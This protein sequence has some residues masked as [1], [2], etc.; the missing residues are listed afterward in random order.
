MTSG[1]KNE[2]V[3]ESYTVVS[4][5]ISS[6]SL[7]L[8]VNDSVCSPADNFVQK[9]LELPITNASTD[10]PSSSHEAPYDWQFLWS[11]GGP[12][13][14]LKNAYGH[15]GTGTIGSMTDMLAT[16]S[17][18]VR[19]AYALSFGFCDGQRLPCTV[20]GNDAFFQNQSYIY[21]TPSSADWMADLMN[22][23]AS[24]KRK[25]FCAFA[26]PGAHDAGMWDATALGILAKESK[27]QQYMIDFAGE[28][29]TVAKAWLIAMAISPALA[30]LAKA[31]LEPAIV[32]QVCINLAFAQKDNT[33]TMLDLGIRYFDFRPGY[34]VFPLP[35]RNGLYH[36]HRF[37]PGCSYDSF[38]RDMLSWLYAHPGEI[39]VVDLRFTEFAVPI[40]WAGDHPVFSPDDFKR[41]END[42]DAYLPKSGGQAMIPDGKALTDA[43]TGAVATVPA[44]GSPVQLGF[45]GDLN[46]SYRDLITNNVRAIFLTNGT[47]FATNLGNPDNATRNDSY[48]DSAYQT[49]QAVNGVVAADAGWIEG[50]IA[51]ALSKQAAFDYTVL[52]LQATASANPNGIALASVGALSSASSPLLYTKAALDSQTYPWLGGGTTGLSTAAL[53]NDRLL[54]FMNDFADNALAAICSRLSKDRLESAFDA[55]TRPWRHL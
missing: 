5:A 38:L 49:L 51:T 8:T 11:L 52:N 46:R 3:V 28:D 53:G 20:G 42:P 41:V 29:S 21:L 35:S 36:Q 33:T 25:P 30:L 32:E 10:D 50:C 1:F 39:V 17:K 16:P 54:C 12:G 37:V 27:F 15:S 44:L 2:I 43:W 9:T 4:S 48:N 13:G 31:F 55:P 23:E 26:L 47:G 22:R 6:S 7:T 19:R 34:C 18:V 40:V 45:V 24:L 14:T